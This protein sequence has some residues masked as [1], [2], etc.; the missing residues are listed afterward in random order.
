M[1]VSP[2]LDFTN[3]K[4]LN[5]GAQHQFFILLDKDITKKQTLTTII[6]IKSYESFQHQNKELSFSFIKTQ[7]EIKPHITLSLIPLLIPD[8]VRIADLMIILT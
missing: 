5:V 3:F 7:K 6:T 4:K 2:Q 8:N 1:I